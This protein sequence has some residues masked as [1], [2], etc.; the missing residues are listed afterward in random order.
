M[1]HSL[2]YS[3]HRGRGALFVGIL[4]FSLSSSLNASPI[5]QSDDA[6]LTAMPASNVGSF[7]AATGRLVD[8]RMAV[9]A[10]VQVEAAVRNREPRA[11]A[12]PRAPTLQKSEGTAV[13]E[14]RPWVEQNLPPD[15]LRN[16]LRS[17]VTGRRA[18]GVTSAPALKHARGAAPDGYDQPAFPDLSDLVL[19]SEI[20]G[21]ALR[22][23]VDVKSTDA[24]LTIFSIF[25]MGNFV[26][27]METSANS[28]IIYEL[29]SGWSAALA[30]GRN[31][32]GLLGY[33]GDLARAGAY[34][35]A[36]RENINY[37]QLAWAWIVD[38]LSSPL[39]VLTMMFA[40]T[41]IFVWGGTKSISILQRR[42]SA[43]RRR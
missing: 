20:A 31:G 11:F 37:L 28:A 43:S 30:N 7:A 39:G 24:D 32:A 41:V 22:A 26:L 6:A 21:A 13:I 12:A 25:G 17:I 23:L 2:T 16:V 29:S 18:N 27:D 8:P 36:T 3:L 42:A 1:L 9:D 40:T 15:T 35:S 10:P 34:P 5:L 19:D 4:V 33:S 38:E 14:D